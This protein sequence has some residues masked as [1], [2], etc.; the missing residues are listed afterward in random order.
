V[1]KGQRLVTLLRASA[2]VLARFQLMPARLP[3]A[4]YDVRRT[5]S[6][7]E[8]GRANHARS[9]RILDLGHAG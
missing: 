4:V 6:P 8:D 5:L 1:I 9:V 7:R 3:W 2:E